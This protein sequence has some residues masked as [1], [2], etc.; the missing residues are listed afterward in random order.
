MFKY[1]FTL[2]FLGHV[3]GDFYFQTESMAGNKKKKQSWIWLHGV[4]YLSAMV[5]CCW[6]FGGSKLIL[7]AVC[8]GAAHFAIDYIKFF[9][10]KK[11]GTVCKIFIADQILHIITIILT[12]I[13]IILLYGTAYENRVLYKIA[14]IMG[15]EIQ[16]AV[17]WLAAALAIH[18]PVNIAIASILNVYRPESKE[19]KQD[20]RNAGRFIGT[21]ERAI[22]LMFIF[23]RQY[24]A[25]GL[26]LTAKSIARYNKIAEDE[27]FAEYYLLGTLMST[28][29]VILISF[30]I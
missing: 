8:A 2:L 4:L 5:V 22:I 13:F 7:P 29:A 27:G 21:L 1:Y 26:V 23:L 20:D 10:D 30:L 6:T 9:W 11:N 28:A 19:K 14:E 16:N 24:S 18:K 17:A 12:A 15:L 3:L 25:I